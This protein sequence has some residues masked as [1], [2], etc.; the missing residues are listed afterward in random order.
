MKNQGLFDLLT[1]ESDLAMALYF[2]QQDIDDGRFTD[3]MASQF[4]HL[5]LQDK[6]ESLLFKHYDEYRDLLNMARGQA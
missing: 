4:E 3:A 1:I 2:M 6:W 5:Y